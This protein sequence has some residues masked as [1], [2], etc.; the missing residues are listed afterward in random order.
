MGPDDLPDD[1]SDDEQ[2]RVKI[3]HPIFKGTPGE[4]PDAHIYAA[5]DW[6]EVMRVRR[7]D[8]ITKFKH[9][10]NHL[11]REWYHSLDLDQFG[12]DWNQFT[13]HFSRYSSTQGRNIKHLHERWRT[14]SFDPAND[15]I[16][17][18]I[19]DVKEAAKQLG[20]GDDAVINLLKA[21]M[22]T[23]LYGTLYGH[24]NLPQ[25][26]TML[27]DIYAHKPQAAASSTTTT[28]GASAPFM[29]IKALPR[30]PEPTLEDKLTHLTDTLY[31]MDIDSKPPKKPFK[32]FIT[33]PCRRFRGSFDKGRSGKGGRFGQFGQSDRRNRFTS[34]RGR[35]RPR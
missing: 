30:T 32:P 31:R 27:K 6:M 5:E 2:P 3:H 34:N 11:A 13:T 18:Y 35:F 19:R 33:P 25:L 14:F 15:D 23:E 28:P 8:F 26:C 1:L 21:T 20:H 29:M 4:R 22:P 10:L 7:D 16:E 12:G 9:T 17:E 24:N